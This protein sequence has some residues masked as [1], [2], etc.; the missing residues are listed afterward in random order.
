MSTNRFISKTFHLFSSSKMKSVL[1]K[2]PGGINQLYLGETTKPILKTGEVL[3]KNICTAVNRA[4]IVQREGKY[5][6]PKGASDILGLESSGIVEQ[7][8]DDEKKWKIG[9]SVMCLLPGGGYGEFVAVH[10]DSVMSIPKGFDFKQSAAISEV[11]LTAFQ[12][13]CQIGGL[14][15]GQ[16]VLIHAGASGVGTA[17]IQ[18]AKA[19]GCDRIITTSSGTKTATCKEYGATLAINYEETPEWDKLLL[20]HAPNGVHVILDP[21]GQKYFHHNCSVLAEDGKI[22]YIA[23]MSGSVV[24]KFNLVSLF[25][26]RGSIHFSALRARTTEYKGE[27]VDSFSKRF[28]S[29]F[30]T[31]ELKPVIDTIMPIEEIA[32]AHE[33]CEKNISAGKIVLTM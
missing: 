23:F 30:E 18:L 15:E 1:L 22:V 20:E 14:Q 5:P 24:E 32:M 31:G 7:V 28:L 4:D 12:T 26:K 27:L 6:P 21:V 16:N 3:V 13:L 11:F 17:A 33:R 2:A 29:K 19:I 10:R 25:R 9:D 8:Q